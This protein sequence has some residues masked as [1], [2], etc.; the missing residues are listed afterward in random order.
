MR[1]RMLSA[2]M[3]AA[4]ALGALPTTAFLRDHSG[5]EPVPPKQP[6]PERF[7]RAEAKRARKAARRLAHSSDAG[8]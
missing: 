5:Y 3:L 1:N 4:A 7:T 6:D 2:G 8:T